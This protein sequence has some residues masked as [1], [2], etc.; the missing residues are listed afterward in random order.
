MNEHEI[1][2]PSDLDVALSA[3]TLRKHA[4]LW[5]V[6]EGRSFRSR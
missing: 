1:S 2:T 4:Q 6:A 3:N 5:K